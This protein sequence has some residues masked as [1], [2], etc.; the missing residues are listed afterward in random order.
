MVKSMVPIL[1]CVAGEKR[2]PKMIAYFLEDSPYALARLKSIAIL[3]QLRLFM[4]DLDFLWSSWVLGFD[5]Q[6]QMDLFKAL[7]GNLNPGRLAVLSLAVLFAIMILLALFNFRV[8]FPKITN[9]HLHYYNQALLIL[10]KHGFCRNTS[11]GPDTFASRISEN[12]SE[13]CAEDFRHITKLFVF[14]DYA[15]ASATNPD[16]LPELKL[17]VRSFKRRYR[18]SV[19]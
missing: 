19:S 18:Y 15:P 7:V 8:W 3:N 11:E 1:R 6:R 9:L 5:Q 2:R 14:H 12:I 13:Q 17:A 16:Q 10:S 4:A